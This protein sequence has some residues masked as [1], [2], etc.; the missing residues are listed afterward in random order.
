M[1][2]KRIIWGIIILAVVLGGYFYYSK[3]KKSKIEYTTADVI[4]GTLTQTVSVTG[5]INP[6]RKYELAFQ[7]TGKVLEMNVDVGDQ[8]TKGQRLAKIDPG[9]L[10]SQ[11]RKSEAEA[12][13]Q[14]QILY[15]MK[16]YDRAYKREEIDAQRARIKSAEAGVDIIN[17]QLKDTVIYSPIDG[18]V[19]KR[20]ANVG[21][22]T[23]V[24]AARSTSILTVAENGDLVI[25]SNIPESDVTKITVGQKAAVTFDSL[26]PDE[27]F[28]AEVTEIDP[29]S[30][31]IQDVVYYGIKLKLDNLSQKL[32][33][34]MSA[35]VDIH[36]AEKTNVLMIPLRAVQSEDNQKFVEILNPDGVSVTKIKI[37]TGLEGD[38]GMVE[39]KAGLQIGQKVVTFTKTL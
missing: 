7:T 23:F 39:V 25:E 15:N 27:I 35:N 34:G 4:Q 11:L 3:S 38:E 36:S 16:R 32:K 21:D 19:L 24:N 20:F 31:V 37:E 29:D 6:D 28:T 14:K 5:T 13:V 18:V 26:M 2:K 30:T 9:T 12:S 17:D 1:K 10:L 33:A 22:T 8:I